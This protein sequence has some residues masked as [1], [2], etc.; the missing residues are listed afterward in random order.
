M[1]FP[2]QFT[3]CQ[4]ATYL[5]SSGQAKEARYA[6]INI[7][8]VIYISNQWENTMFRG[9]LK[10][11]CGLLCMLLRPLQERLRQCKSLR[12]RNHPGQEI[13]GTRNPPRQEIPQDKKS[14]GIRNPPGQEIPRDKKSPGTRNPPGQKSP[15]KSRAGTASIYIKE[16]QFYSFLTYLL[17]QF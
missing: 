11:S 4:N 15:G 14:L 1:K 3:I 7:T 16:W 10:K 9:R 8:R 12:T 17:P 6:Q 2:I 5:T 13:P